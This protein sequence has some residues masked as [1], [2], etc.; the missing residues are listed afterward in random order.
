MP[1]LSKVWGDLPTG[2]SSPRSGRRSSPQWATPLAVSTAVADSPGQEPRRYP[3]GHRHQQDPAAAQGPANLSLPPRS[4]QRDTDLPRQPGLGLGHAQRPLPGEA[5]TGDTAT[6][7]HQCSDGDDQGYTF[8]AGLQYMVVSQNRP[9]F[10]PPLRF[11]FIATS[12]MIL[13]LTLVE[14]RHGSSRIRGPAR[15]A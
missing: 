7:R 14:H 4:G 1:P 5:Q 13:A 12:G 10:R 11:G 6:A 15:P 8:P 3:A 2:C 9:A